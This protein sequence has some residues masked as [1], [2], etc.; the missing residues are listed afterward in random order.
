MAISLGEEL[1]L[2]YKFRFF[3]QNNGVEK[4]NDNIRI[5]EDN[6]FS[7]EIAGV[8]GLRKRLTRRENFPGDAERKVFG[9]DE[10][11]ASLA[12]CFFF[13]SFCVLDLGRGN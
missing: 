2:L 7:G 1:T 12:F 9:D 6:W 8:K 4:E 11:A 13:S 5:S 3:F 10:I